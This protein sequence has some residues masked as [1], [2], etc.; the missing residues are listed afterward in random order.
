MQFEWD[1]HKAALNLAKHGIGFEL[2]TAVWK[3]P[4]ALLTYDRTVNGDERFRM[5]GVV[6]T[7]TLLLVIHSYPD[8]VD[9]TKIRLISARRATKSERRTYENRRS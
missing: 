4:F 1:D 7:M 3:D 9:D 8:P 6:G 2:A 5:V